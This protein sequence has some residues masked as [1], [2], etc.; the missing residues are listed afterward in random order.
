MPCGM[1]LFF[2]QAEAVILPC[3]SRIY[4][5]KRLITHAFYDI[6]FRIDHVILWPADTELR[7]CHGIIRS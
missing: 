4:P 6:P 3:E 1:E 7:I 2:Y 5:K